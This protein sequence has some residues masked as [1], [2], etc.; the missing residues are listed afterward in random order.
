[1]WK[2]AR[3]GKGMVEGIRRRDELEE[4]ERRRREGGGK[5]LGWEEEKESED[6]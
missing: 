4:G 6:V 2:K 1:M 3:G 5:E